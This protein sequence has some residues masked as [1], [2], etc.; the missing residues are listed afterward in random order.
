[1]LAFGAVLET[2]VEAA[3][4]VVL[5]AVLE[6]AEGSDKRCSRPFLLRAET[7]Q[8]F[9]SRVFSSWASSG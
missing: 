2:V 5:R 9:L 1:L 7:G 3:L 8:S 6:T 4:E